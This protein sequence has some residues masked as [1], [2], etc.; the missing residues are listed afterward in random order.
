MTWGDS[1]GQHLESAGSVRLLVPANSDHLRLV[2]VVAADIA[3]AQ[4][5]DF[6]FISELQMAIDE[7]CAQ[8]IGVALAGS[9]LKCEFQQ[10]GSELLLTVS[11][12]TAMNTKISQ[13]TFGWHVLS[14]LS[15]HV[16][17][18]AG[19]VDETARTTWTGMRIRKGARS[20][21]R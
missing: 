3:A 2:R 4:D 19:P 10:D 13:T 11:A 5:F 6:E 16:E 17:L 21:D 14:T 15:D 7:A 9:K 1:D 18:I 20:A 12:P 8:L